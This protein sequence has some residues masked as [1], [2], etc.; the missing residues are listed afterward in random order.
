MTK[1]RSTVLKVVFD[2]ERTASD[3]ARRVELRGV[4]VKHTCRSKPEGKTRLG[5]LVFHLWFGSPSRSPP[6]TSRRIA[7][8]SPS[9]EA[10]G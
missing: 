8:G 9:F 7:D 4:T 5:F 10:E 3:E 1:V 6:R 2:A